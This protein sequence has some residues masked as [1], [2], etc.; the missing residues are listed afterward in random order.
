M[1]IFD[2]PTPVDGLRGGLDAGPASPPKN[3]K[4][5]TSHPSSGGRPRD[6]FWNLITPAYLK[7]VWQQQ[8]SGIEVHFTGKAWQHVISKNVGRDPLF[9]YARL[10]MLVAF[11]MAFGRPLELDDVMTLVREDAD[12]TTGKAQAICRIKFHMMREQMLLSKN[13]ALRLAGRPVLPST[14]VMKMQPDPDQVRLNCTFTKV[15]AIVVH[16]AHVAEFFA[17][18]HAFVED[19]RRRASQDAAM[20]PEPD[21]FLVLAECLVRQGGPD[22]APRYPRWS[23]VGSHTGLPSGKRN[24]VSGS[25]W[26]FLPRIGKVFKC[27]SSTSDSLLLYALSASAEAKAGKRE[28]R[29]VASVDRE[30]FLDMNLGDRAA[31]VKEATDRATGAAWDDADTGVDFSQYE[32]APEGAAAEQE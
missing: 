29:S 31:Q 2:E 28:P 12:P 3:V 13:R 10:D 26:R 22:N 5:D 8:Q 14:E 27:G 9:C 20:M 32:V 16:T 19:Y 18:V 15:M 17:D 4:R 23:L 24:P 30:K 11:S 21:M 6:D 7:W 1:G 25:L